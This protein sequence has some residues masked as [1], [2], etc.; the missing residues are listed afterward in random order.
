MLSTCVASLPLLPV[1][2][3]LMHQMSLNVFKLPFTLQ[4]EG[5]IFSVHHIQTEI[6]SRP[7]T[8]FLFPVPPLPSLPVLLCYF[9]TVFA[10]VMSPPLCTWARKVG[11][12]FVFCCFKAAWLSD[13]SWGETLVTCPTFCA[14]WSQETEWGHSFCRRPPW[15]ELVVSK[16]R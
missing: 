8:S 11:E 1:H 4:N 2:F 7:G 3:H 15:S 9:P 5:R 12:N 14:C 6:L 10:R 13:I 16:L